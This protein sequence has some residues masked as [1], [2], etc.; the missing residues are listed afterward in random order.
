[1]KL[2]SKFNVGDIVDYENY[3]TDQREHGKVCEVN[4]LNGFRYGVL[5][6]DDNDSYWHEED[7]LKLVKKGVQI[8]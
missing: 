7:E 6:K 2:K 4:Y 8:C 3:M 5:D 1:M